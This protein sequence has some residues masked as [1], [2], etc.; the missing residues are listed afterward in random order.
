MHRPI[1]LL[2]CPRSGTT[3]F[4]HLLSMHKDLAWVSHY[5]NRF[6]R[7][8]LT[9]L[10]H[11]VF[12]IPVLGNR[13]RLSR[14]P[15]L[16]VAC[17]PWNFWT[18][19]LSRFR[20][21]AG[22][23]EPAR[24]QTADDMSDEEVHKVRKV[25]RTICRCQ[26]RS[27]FLTKYTEFAR[28][29]YML[30]AFPDARFVHVVRDGRAVVNSLRNK[31]LIGEFGNWEERDWWAAAFPE[32]WR[33][34]FYENHHSPVGLMIYLWKYFIS[35]IRQEAA[36]LPKEQYLEIHYSD[37]VR[38]T[39]PTLERTLGFCDLDVTRQF[40]WCV[41]RTRVSSMDYKWKE[42]LD[43]DQQR[44]IEE[45]ICEEEYRALLDD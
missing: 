33:R 32:A 26:L 23:Q 30:K 14:G 31:V 13:F 29:H 28:I 37:L 1:I 17:E 4:L 36:D 9:A 21:K 27:R 22:G 41:E 12:R 20:Q 15:V 10:Y 11:N 3:I 7:W 45:I 25:V 5:Q 18:T 42:G 40:R 6:P 24:P 39:M 8:P 43:A 16:P 34:D 2:G 38:E 44:T 35:L 19:L